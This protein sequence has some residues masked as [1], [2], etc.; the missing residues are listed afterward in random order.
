MNRA[1]R[2][3]AIHKI[4]NI[5]EDATDNKQKEYMGLGVYYELKYSMYG[6]FTLTTF[7]EFEGGRNVYPQIGKVEKRGNLSLTDDLKVE[8]I[9]KQY[10]KALKDMYQQE[11]RYREEY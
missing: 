2:E 11:T 10:E 8:D 6:Y 9:E 1:K 4:I 3:E 7:M 5:V